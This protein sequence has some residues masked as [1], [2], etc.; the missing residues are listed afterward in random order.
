MW[1]V[2]LSSNALYVFWAIDV[3]RV[4]E[5]GPVHRI[6]NYELLFEHCTIIYLAQLPTTLV[7]Q[8]PRPPTTALFRDD[9]PQGTAVESLACVFLK[10]REL[11][12]CILPWRK[13]RQ[14]PR[15]VLACARKPQY[16]VK[17]K[18]SKAGNRRSPNSAQLLQLRFDVSKL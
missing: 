5:G 14:Y 4:E 1:T 10:S 13:Q 16:A 17:E 11:Q 15:F 6:L 9:F 2:L 18:V 7:L 3:R 8:G 12:A